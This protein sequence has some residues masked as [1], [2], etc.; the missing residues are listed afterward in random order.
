MRFWAAATEHYHDKIA[1]YKIALYLPNATFPC[2]NL[3]MREPATAGL[4]SRLMVDVVRYANLT[5]ARRMQRSRATLARR[6]QEELG[7]PVRDFLTDIRTWSFDQS[8]RRRV[9]WSPANA[10]R[11]TIFTL[12]G[13]A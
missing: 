9:S 5:L 12:P 11:S 10:D 7:R 1:L 2:A 8:V 13:Q 6:F 4:G 3:A